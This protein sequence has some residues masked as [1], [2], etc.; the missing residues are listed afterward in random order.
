MADDHAPRK[1]PPS[2][3]LGGGVNVPHTCWMDQRPSGHKP[4][5]GASSPLCNVCTQTTSPLYPCVLSETC[6][7]PPSCVLE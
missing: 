4:Y 1:A 5:G 6:T 3:G 2:T 7:I